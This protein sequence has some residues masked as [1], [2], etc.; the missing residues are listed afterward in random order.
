MAFKKREAAAIVG[1]ATSRLSAMKQIDTDQGST[2]DY[3]GPSG[4]LTAT[5][6][7]AE[8]THNAELIEEYNQLLGQA[9]AKGNDIAASDTK[10]E[11]NYSRVLSSAFGKFGEDSNEIEQL[12]GTRKSERKPPKRKPKP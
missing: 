7:E 12:G 4:A 1:K 3:G 9:D 8:I 2:I 6:F 10:I 11:S 5:E